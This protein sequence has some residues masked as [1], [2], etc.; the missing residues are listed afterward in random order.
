MAA[1]AM[2]SQS[3]WLTTAGNS[4]GGRT[5]RQWGLLSRGWLENGPPSLLSGRHPV[6]DAPSSLSD[7]V[8]RVGLLWLGCARLR[9]ALTLNAVCSR[10]CS[11]AHWV[12]AFADVTS[13]AAPFFSLPP[14]HG[15]HT[16]QAQDKYCQR[17]TQIHAQQPVGVGPRPTCPSRRWAWRHLRHDSALIDQSKE[18]CVLKPACVNHHA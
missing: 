10:Q 2:W 7:R 17:H 13:R 18:V 5:R 15:K 12:N 1:R 9:P 14:P 11:G 8:T 4:G 3:A 6:D 16:C